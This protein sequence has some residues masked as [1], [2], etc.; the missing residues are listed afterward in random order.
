[1]EFPIV[2]MLVYM[3]RCYNMVSPILYH[4]PSDKQVPK[5][6]IVT[7]VTLCYRAL[8]WRDA[9]CDGGCIV[10]YGAPVMRMRD[11]LYIPYSSF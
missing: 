2:H 8:H 6:T 7:L 10:L 5:M 4:M 1:M 11:I 9:T 3:H